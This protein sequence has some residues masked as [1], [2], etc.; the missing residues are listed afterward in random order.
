MILPRIEIAPTET[1]L[2]F[3]QRRQ[4]TIIPTFVIKINESPGQSF[5]MVGIYS[6]EHVFS[7]GQLFVVLT[8]H[9]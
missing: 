9:A 2:P 6:I 5:N 8:R 3:T 1:D 4:F 7:Q